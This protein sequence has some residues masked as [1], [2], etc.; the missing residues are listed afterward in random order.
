MDRGAARRRE[1]ERRLSL[2]A[3]MEFPVIETEGTL[4]VKARAANL[5]AT[6]IA[7]VCYSQPKHDPDAVVELEL[8]LP[9]VEGPMRVM[10]TPVWC[11]GFRLGLR[12]EEV[13]DA[14]RL[15]LAEV[16]DRMRGREPF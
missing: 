12:F 15:E 7:L 13:A 4:T 16:L 11:D 9:G 6:G 3:D 2:R 10:A 14:D 5:S 8:H 1:I